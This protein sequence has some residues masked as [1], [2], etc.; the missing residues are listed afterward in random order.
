[1]KKQVAIIL[2]GGVGGGDFSQGCPPIVNIVNGLSM[3]YDITVYSIYPA[4][5]G[6][7][8]R[9]FKFRSAN[10]KIAS[11]KIRTIITCFHLLFDH[12]V[13][14]FD[15]LH[16]F[17]AYPAGT[18]AVLFG[19]VF[20]IPSLITIQGGEAA[21]IKEINYGNMLKSRLRKITLWT[22]DHA[23]VLNSVSKFLLKGLTAYGLKRNVGIV[24]P[25]GADTNLFVKTKKSD[26]E[27]LQIIHVANIT[28]VKDQTT[29]LKTF[30]LILENQPAKLRIV[31]GDFMNK[32]LHSLIHEMNLNDHVEMIGSVP[33][34]E[35]A[36]YYNQ[37]DIM[38]HTSLHEGLPSVAAEAMACGVVVSAT[39]VG[40]FDDLG[41]PYFELA[42][43]G[44]Y[45]NLARKVLE[46][47]S[48]K[49]KLNALQVKSEAW[50]KQFNL[51]WTVAEFNKL[52]NSLVD[53]RAK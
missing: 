21:A 27:V 23:T 31:G 35:L 3:Y 13:Y 15:L 8:P 50:A 43:V 24:I 36:D 18:I 48:N 42:D 22:C 46:L 10:S 9:G 26:S 12:L 37:A 2:Q 11:T 38:V 33:N 52:Y 39:R 1:M 17:W 45:R 34:Q 32:K 20:K 41:D 6:Y 30:A 14:K 51:D 5:A 40:I 7:A 28:E 16:A 47:W 25:F 29:L 4:N 19:K 49:E 44:D 53:V